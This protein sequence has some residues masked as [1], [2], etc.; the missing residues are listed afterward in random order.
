MARDV[1]R[2]LGKRF[3]VADSPRRPD[4]L[5]PRVTTWLTVEPVT[6]LIVLRAHLLDAAK[7]Q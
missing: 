3:D 6:R 4:R 1:L 2:A 5:W 7:H